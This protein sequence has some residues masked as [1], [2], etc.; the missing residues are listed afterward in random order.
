MQIF[1]ALISGALTDKYGRRLTTA[2][3]DFLSW[4]IPPFIWAVAQ[5]IRYF[6]LAAIFNAMWRIPSN[7][8]TCLLVE[9]AEEDELVHI[10]IWIYIAG[11]LSAFFAPLAGVLFGSSNLFPA[12]RIMYLFAFVLMTAKTWVLYRYSTETRQGQIRMDETRDQRLFSL[13]GGY[14][15]VFKDVLTYPKN[16]HRDWDYD[17]DEYLCDWSTTP[18]GPSLS[19]K[20]TAFPQNI[21][22][23]TLL[24]RSAIL[25]VLYFVLVPRSECPQISNTDVGWFDGLIVSQIILVSMP[26]GNY[27]LLLVSVLIEALSLTMYRPLHDSLVIISIDKVERAR[28]NAIM[29]VI[30]ISLTSPFGWIAGQLSEINRIYPFVLNMILFVVGAI[31]VLL[32][33]GASKHAEDIPGAGYGQDHDFSISERISTPSLTICLDPSLIKIY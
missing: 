31:L 5:D 19:Q 4:G 18:F 23:F 7:A 28:I 17:S 24:H 9:D 14:W 10:W 11:L 16:P 21:S 25:L 27:W 29:A 13:L 20:N 15:D 6:I 30:V 2:V 22:P 26:P 32:A 8:W 3:S 1:F 12:V 33:W